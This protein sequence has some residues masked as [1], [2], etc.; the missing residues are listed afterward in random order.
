MVASLLPAKFD[1][2]KSLNI[3]QAIII[4]LSVCYFFL[5]HA[6]ADMQIELNLYKIKNC[7]Q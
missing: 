7:S 1:V 3:Q 4:K 6:I 2:S 5:F